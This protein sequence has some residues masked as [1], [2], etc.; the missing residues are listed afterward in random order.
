M[1]LL[2]S[3]TPISVESYDEK[4]TEN[5]RKYRKLKYISRTI[6]EL[7]E[8]SKTNIAAWIK[9]TFRRMSE[10][11]HTYHYLNFSFFSRNIPFFYSFLI[12]KKTK[13]G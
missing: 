1:K 9:N 2:E 3:N 5:Y 6:L 4:A 8:S 10:H 13:T 11:N 12:F 7:A